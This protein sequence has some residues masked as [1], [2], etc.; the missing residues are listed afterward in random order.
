[1]AA[2]AGLVEVASASLGAL[3]ATK[4]RLPNGLEVVLVPDPHATSV[5]YTTWFRVGSRN[6]NE[7]AGET[8]LAHLFE[9]LMFTQTK[10]MA[11]DEFDRVIEAAGGNSNAMTYY[12]FT[13]YVDDLPPQELALAARLESDRMTNLDLRKRQIDTERDVVVEERLSA[14]EDSVDGT[15]DELLFKQAFKITRIAGRSLAG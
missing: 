2:S 13:A 5:S 10:T 1:V 9:H 12:D 7:R 14:V 6:E 15:M 3:T 8:G 4:W 11:A